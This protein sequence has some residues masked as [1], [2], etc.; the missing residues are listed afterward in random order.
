V[1][2]LSTDVTDTLGAAVTILADFA[3]HLQTL[4]PT[5]QPPAGS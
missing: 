1:I 4:R 3:A 5:L 2:A